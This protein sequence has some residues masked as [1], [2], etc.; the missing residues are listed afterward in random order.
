[1][2]VA[3]WNVNGIRAR[4]AQML[5]FLEREAPHVLCLQE[6]KASPEQ[7]PVSLA[8]RAGYRARWHGHKGYS[9]VALLLDAARFPD[10][11]FYHPAFD[12]ECRIVAADHGDRVFA[13]VYVPNGGKDLPAKIAFL[14]A[15]GA[16]AG[17]IAASGRRLILCGDLNV[18][19]TDVD[20][21][22][23]DRRRMVGQLPEERALIDALFGHDLVDVGRF[24]DPDNDRLYTWW[25]P[26]R[27][28]RARNIGWRIDYVAA[29]KAYVDATV[30]C[31][32][33]REVGTSDH[34]PVVAE[35]LD[36]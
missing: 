26:W 33:Q 28:L 9:G 25:A 23:T 21:H 24:V 10:P 32:S 17:Q 11:A 2:K 8:Q 4:E 30:R 34:G 5:E 18:A 12:H 13:S 14:T 36:S 20:V 29:H 7:V 35:L 19:R 15:L 3:T 31:V 16:W 22:P 27:N 6:T 1:M